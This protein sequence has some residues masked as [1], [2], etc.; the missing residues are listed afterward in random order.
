MV[1][2]VL[3]ISLGFFYVLCYLIVIILWSRLYYIFIYMRG[4]WDIEFKYF[5]YDYIVSRDVYIK[6]I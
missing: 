3:G 5:I 2:Y 4:N 1:Y 6:V